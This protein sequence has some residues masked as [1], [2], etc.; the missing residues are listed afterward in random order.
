MHFSSLPC[1]AYFILIDMIAV[2]ICGEASHL[3]S[4]SLCGPCHPSSNLPFWVHI[5]SPQHLVSS[6]F[7]LLSLTST[8][9][10]SK[11]S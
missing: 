7:R 9:H 1:L 5:Y 10:N 11:S 4:C 3:W 6:S 2:I 8:F